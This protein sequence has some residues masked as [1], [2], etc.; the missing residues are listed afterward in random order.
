MTRVC[1]LCRLNDCVT[2]LYRMT[3]VDGML[4]MAKQAKSNDVFIC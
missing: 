3:F 1:D 4:V 2:V